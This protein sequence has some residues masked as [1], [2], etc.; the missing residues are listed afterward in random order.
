MSRNNQQYTDVSRAL[1]DYM[2]NKIPTEQALKAVAEVL[3][4]AYRKP[5]STKATRD[6]I[7]DWEIKIDGLNQTFSDYLRLIYQ[8]AK[9]DSAH[10][11]RAARGLLAIA[12]LSPGAAAT[13]FLALGY[14]YK[15][16]GSPFDAIEPLKRAAEELH[17]VGD[18][19]NEALA[20]LDLSEVFLA[21]KQLNDA[22][23]AA[24]RAIQCSKEADREG[25]LVKALKT[26]GPIL[27]K[28]GKS[29]EAVESLRLAVQ[30]R[31][32]L[33]PDVI[34]EQSVEDIQSFLFQ[35]GVAARNFG[36]YEEAILA[37]QEMYETDCNAEHM[38]HQAHS[39][40]EIAYTYQSAGEQA[41]AKDYLNRAADLASE[42]GEREHAMRWQIQAAG[43]DRSIDLDELGPL[44]KYAA[45]DSQ[46][47]RWIATVATAFAKAGRSNESL[48]AAM[49]ALS[50]A[51]SEGDN[52]LEVNCRSVIARIHSDRGELDKAIRET[53][54]AISMADRNGFA[55]ISLELRANLA[56]A[57]LRKEDYQNAQAVLN[58]AIIRG[59]QQLEKTP[60]SEFRQAIMGSL[61]R[62]FENY[63]ALYSRFQMH[64][65]LIWIT[66]Q[67]RA[68]NLLGWLEM[69]TL[70]SNESWDNSF[71]NEASKRLLNL[72]ACEV[73]LEVRHLIGELD[74]RSISDIISRRNAARKWLEDRLSLE[75]RTGISWAQIH[76]EPDRVKD[77]LGQ[78]CQGDEAI[79]CLFSV[80][81]GICL[82][83]IHRTKSEV[84]KCGEFIA[85]DRAERQALI[86]SWME[87]DS[88][89]EDEERAAY[90]RFAYELNSKL[91][92]PVSR[93]LK[94]SQAKKL[95]IVPNREL[96]QL[97]YWD[98][99]DKNKRL[100]SFTVSPSLG[101]LEICLER[102]RPLRGPT[103]VLL[104]PEFD[105]PRGLINAPWEV[106]LVESSRS[107][108]AIL[109]PESISA[110]EKSAIEA[111]LIHAAT[112][113]LFFAEQ[114][115]H[116]GLLVSDAVNDAPNRSDLLTQLVDG[117]LNR[118]QTLKDGKGR[119]LT[120][121]EVI[122][123]LECP[124][125][126][127]VVLSAC[128]SGLAR[129]HGGGE[130]TGLPNSFLIAGARSVVASLWPVDD[131]A[132]A[133][134]MASFYDI[135]QGGHGDE[136]NPAR[137]LFRAR[138]RL[139][140]MSRPEAIARLGRSRQIPDYD[141]PFAHPLHMNMFQCFGAW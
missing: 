22:E 80:S 76:K 52:D 87:D 7:S 75:N 128:Q 67:A 120:V 26:L 97:P 4:P 93:L 100:E 105:G 129:I 60:S 68:Q 141:L 135:W 9:T 140:S 39:L 110:I 69:E 45:T 21:V 35:L 11:L 44:G 23:R 1:A 132:A 28:Q 82:V 48:D 70:L 43:D 138:E 17:G 14:V 42:A 91:F 81:E 107:D 134:M 47:A 130:M 66:E 95:A 133:L 137:A 106:G 18:Q 126:A 111:N 84:V 49:I 73:E 94:R 74:H 5:D 85:W 123:R 3:I 122:S 101:V 98:L 32:A 119:L 118:V 92:D 90:E 83:L 25:T 15:V 127:L 50:W 117:E 71:R 13:S 125:C 115:Y 65:G 64:D 102:R 36:L 131:A 136:T 114:P 46:S 19:I 34:A 53:R 104:D 108:H 37:F 62:I 112:H 56:N 54:R 96:T 59:H 16:A 79:I 61:S 63:A 57:L 38:F 27:S 72:R 8:S 124:Q 103:V 10:A 116:S 55:A 89:Y 31:R 2:K 6:E 58:D 88:I 29:S 20:Y 33:D 86:N 30:K 109:K 77:K 40:S 113:G 99:L 139:A 51:E 24:R 41:R 12:G 78:I 121:G